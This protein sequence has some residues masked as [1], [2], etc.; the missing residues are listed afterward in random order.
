MTPLE[1]AVLNEKLLEQERRFVETSK[2]MVPILQAM[3][4]VY[5]D[6]LQ[7]AARAFAASR[8]GKP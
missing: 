4:N 3:A 8:Q 7:K 1:R 2:G 6:T 5:A